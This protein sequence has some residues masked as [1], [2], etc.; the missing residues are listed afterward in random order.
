MRQLKSLIVALVLVAGP[1]LAGPFE[2]G[3]TAYERKDY[4]TALRLWRP[5]AIGGDVHAQRN[6]GSMYADGQGV[7][8]DHQQ[9]VF[10]YRKAAEK[11]N[12]DAQ[13]SL[14]KAYEFGQ[15][16]PKDDERAVFWFREAA[17]QGHAT[18]QNNLGVMYAKG[19]GV[20]KN[21]LQ[22]AYWY[23]KAAMQDHAVGQ[24]N[25]GRMYDFGRSM[26]K[27][28]QQAAYWYRKAAEQGDV[29]GQINLGAMYDDGRGVPKNDT[30]AAYWYRKAAEQG[31]A[32]GQFNLGLMYSNGQGIPKDDQQALHWYRKA[33][34][35]GNGSAQKNLGNMFARGQ[36][37]PKD[38]QM[39]YYWSLL[40]SVGGDADAIRNRDSLER[41]LTAEQRAAAQVDARNWKPNVAKAPADATR[42]PRPDPGS[43]ADSTGS[44]FRVAAARIVTNNHVVENC[45]RIRVNG[46][47]D[48]RVLARDG[49]NDLAIV[50]AA[51]DRGPAASVRATRSR[52]GEEVAIAGYP[53]QHLLSGLS[54]TKGNVSRLSGLAGDSR[55][56]QISAPVQ[57]GNSG[58]PLLDAS[59]NVVGVVVSKL[60]TLRVAKATGDIP[61]NV[62]FALNA[63]VLRAFLDANAVEYADGTSARSLSPTEVASRAAR[64]TVLV[65]CWN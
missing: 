19:Q 3:L 13:H 7:P 60:D 20:P 45:S 61:Q 26:P 42:L 46:S 64:F 43:R 63:N 53:L 21:D 40:A 57:P 32:V 10:W 62:N 44:G 59:A 12:A 35:Q 52:L 18:S 25:L 33:A 8:I 16:V 41:R 34:D 56:L 28:D 50:E 58:G 23:R 11:G 31:N 2:D 9:A 29:G 15:G 55:L 4:A 30:Q 6:L 54:V 37:V 49:R 24:A 51:E 5:L 36:G 48:A 47:I 38:D 17:E 1:V 39:A 22:A 14:G 27:D 65:E